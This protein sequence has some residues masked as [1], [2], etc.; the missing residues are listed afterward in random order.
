MNDLCRWSKRPLAYLWHYV[1]LR[2][3]SH[4]FILC[5]V[6]VAVGCSV[7]TQ[8]GVKFLVDSLTTQSHSIWVAFCLL[9]SL[10]AADN[11]CWR[12]AS[13]TASFTFVQVTG[14]IRRDLF[15]HLTMHS[16]SFFSE[17]L[18]GVLTS[19]ITATSNATFAVENMFVWNVLPPCLATVG[20][21]FYLAW[22]NLG[23]ALT[24]LALASVM[25][26]VL[27]ELASRGRP[28]HHDF[29]TK[30][31]AVDGEMIDVI[32]NMALVKSFC[33]LGREHSRFD[34]TVHHELSARR[35]SLLYLEKLRLGHALTTVLLTIC[36][37]AWALVLR[38]KGMVSVGDVVMVCTLGM[39]VLSATR[40]LAVALVDV[41]QHMARFSEAIETL[42]VPHQLR[43]HPNATVLDRNSA[44]LVFENISFRYPKG[45]Q[46][47]RNF[48]L[49][50]KSGQRI[51]LVGPSGG[52]KST[53]FVLLQRF[54]EVDGGRI[55]IDGQ[56]VNQ[57]TQDSL[58]GAIA[59]VPQDTALFNRSLLENIRYG[60]PEAS[61][62]EVWRAAMDARCGSFV[63]SLP[64]KVTTIV[65]EAYMDFVD[66]AGLGSVVDLVGK[67]KRVVILRTFSKIHGM[68]GVRVG[69]GIARPDIASELA[70]TRMSSANIFAMRAARASLA[71][72]AFLTDTRR[73][74]LA[75]RVRITTELERLGLTYADPQGNFVFFD[76]G[77]PLSRF[78][79]SM[80]ERNILVGRHFP[81]FDTWCR[82]T[83]GTEPEVAAFLDALR[84]VTPGRHA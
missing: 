64:E 69:Y 45:E 60:R 83:I 53:L 40:D 25:V 78:S 14:D 19:R 27:F 8:Y 70:E 58:W 79:Q 28:L 21:I 77:M 32:G 56:N 30:A 42:L 66:G 35:R 31:A 12:L 84:A 47:F 71:D 55:L 81:P 2:P 48:D 57:I 22:V 38:Q 11:L 7:S 41:T 80:R 82:I 43:D 76:T 75:S 29:A 74:I 15:R 18:P 46:I 61:D 49:R 67:G 51:G 6:V 24:L 73:R 23:M 54:Y 65:D 39:S 9:L 4:A 3:K 13:W 36:L 20:A 72:H 17:R 26:V 16:H 5:A 34:Q 63:E 52:G 62:E 44:D 59:T 50:I 37:L 68:A 10:I 33:G 1:T